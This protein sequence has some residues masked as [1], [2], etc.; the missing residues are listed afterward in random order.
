[1]GRIA[2][3]L[4]VPRHAYS[5]LVYLSDEGM[6]TLSDLHKILGTDA[7][8][9]FELD[10]TILIHLSHNDYSLLLRVKGEELMLGDE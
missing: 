10:G 6:E 7:T 9:S 2:A 8:F 1:M 4:Y 3:G 5:Y